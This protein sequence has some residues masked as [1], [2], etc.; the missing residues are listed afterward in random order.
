MLEMDSDR[1]DPVCRALSFYLF[2]TRNSDDK[3]IE[4][5]SWSFGWK[6]VIGN[7]DIV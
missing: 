1:W 7:C 5:M 4:T 3:F 2:V 6:S